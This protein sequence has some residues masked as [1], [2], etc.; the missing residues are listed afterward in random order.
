MN[1]AASFYRTKIIEIKISRLERKEQRQ[2]ML[3]KAMFPPRKPV[4]KKVQIRNE[5]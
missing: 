2:R 4:Q 5:G 3:G 1:L